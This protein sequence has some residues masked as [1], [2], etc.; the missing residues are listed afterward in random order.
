MGIMMEKKKK[1]KK[2]NNNNNKQSIT[3]RPSQEA[4]T[5]TRVKLSSTLYGPLYTA[6]YSGKGLPLRASPT[7]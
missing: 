1:K 5:R 7:T 3:V 4:V 2:T 6:P